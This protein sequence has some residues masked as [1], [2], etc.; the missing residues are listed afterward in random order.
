MR[1]KIATS[2]E[3]QYGKWERIERVITNY[4]RLI[5]KSPEDLADA[6]VSA[7]Y[8]EGDVCPPNHSQTNDLCLQADGCRRCWLHWL[9][10]EVDT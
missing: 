8:N 4:D 6:I 10:K 7:Q 1:F 3:N 5:Q 2:G 9:N